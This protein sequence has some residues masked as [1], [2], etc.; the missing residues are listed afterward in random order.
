VTAKEAVTAPELPSTTVTSSTE[1]AGRGSSSVI[2]PRPDPSTTVAPTALDRSRVY[3]S[4]VS[5][6]VSPA[7]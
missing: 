6:S 5:S 4:C 3:V 1:S 2:V 7:T